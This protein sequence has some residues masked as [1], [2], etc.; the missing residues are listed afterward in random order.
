M[1]ALSH[2]T[3]VVESAWTL[4]DGIR[5]AIRVIPHDEEGKKPRGKAGRGLL[6]VAKPDQTISDLL[7][8]VGQFYD[9]EGSWDAFTSGEAGGV[10]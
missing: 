3:L 10:S 5:P 6:V 9:Q 2:A 8:V 7:R 4:G 1:S